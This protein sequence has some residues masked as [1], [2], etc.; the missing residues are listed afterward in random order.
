MREPV[1]PG[2]EA[3]L[4]QGIVAHLRPGMTPEQVRQVMG[5]SPRRAARQILYHRYLEQWLYD[6]PTSV[7]L[8]FDCRRGQP[9]RL[10]SILPE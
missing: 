6:Q 1:R 10:Q 2:L 9:A 4:P 7:R 3:E 5:G 8:E